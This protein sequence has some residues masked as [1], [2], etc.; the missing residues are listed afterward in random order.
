MQLASLWE[1]VASPTHLKFNHVFLWKAYWHG[2]EV[3]GRR[4][5]F[6]PTHWLYLLGCCEHLGVDD[7]ALCFVF[8]SLS[9]Y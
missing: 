4:F 6:S 3:G 1:L 8:S 2:K 7:G 9:R 5:W